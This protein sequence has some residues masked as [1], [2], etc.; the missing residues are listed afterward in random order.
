MF[1]SNTEDVLIVS[2]LLP[3][4]SPLTTGAVRRNH[5]TKDVTEENLQREVSLYLKGA[6]DREGGRKERQKNV[7]NG[8]RGI[9]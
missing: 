7:G 5:S 4:P 6:A 8:G 1:L 9:A 3:N 2:S